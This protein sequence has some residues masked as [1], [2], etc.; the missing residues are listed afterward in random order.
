MFRFYG[1]LNDF[2]PPERRQRAFVHRFEV[3]APVKDMIEGLG[4]PHPEVDLIL[5]NGRSVDFAYSVQDGDR[6]SVYPMF[7]SLDITPL[8]RV[9]PHPL[10]RPRFV[11]DA[12]LGKL[13][14]YLRML[15]FDALY[16]N[17]YGDHELAAISAA[18]RRILLTRDAGLLK[19]S[20]VTHGYWL[21]STDA[22]QQLVE[23]VRRF[24]LWRQIEPFTRCM[25][26]NTP[27]EEAREEDLAAV[28]EQARRCYQEFW[29]CPECRRVYWQG[30][31]YQRMQ[32][33]I[34]ALGLR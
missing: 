13:A 12:H 3:S 14:G 19:H 5:A 10:R 16:R 32:G 29:R 28:P 18:E 25:R 21:R 11:L 8:V 1:E 31:H 2:L 9:R 7:E 26:C 6:I 30:S 20:V 17:D 23:V 22:R 34:K 27:L 24:D 33:W 4:V 15:G